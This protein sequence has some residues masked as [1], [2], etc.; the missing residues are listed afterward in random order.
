VIPT[1][2]EAES[3][4]A[5]L[6]ELPRGIVGRVI[7]VDGGSTDGNSVPDANSSG[8][9]TWDGRIF[10]KP[11][12]LTDLSYLEGFGLGVA[13]TYVNNSGVT[14]AT[15]TTSLLASD[16]TTG[17]Q[18]M[19]SYRS[20]TATGFNNATIARGI[21]RRLVPQSYWYYGP[22]YL[23]GEYVRE[24][25]QVFR[26]VS[27]KL[28]LANTLNNTAWQ[29]QGGVFL[30]GEHEGY[31]S[32][33]PDR[34][35]GKGGFGAWELVARYHELRYDNDTFS[36]GSNSFANPATSVRAAHAKGVGLNWYLTRVFKVQLD[37]EDTSFLGGAA[38]GSRADERVITSQ[39]ALI[40]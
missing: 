12:A 4:G 11:F 33:T 5:A 27:T 18:S 17:Q 13:G 35:V 39:F 24:S 3:I 15:T 7:V 19:F 16:K 38:V 29:I 2:N 30:T 26:Q 22:V 36:G 9:S 1:F 20:D 25:Q 32:A 40:F 10:S 14:T 31:D 28:G 8:K 21:E 23:L 37:F 34:E 6:T